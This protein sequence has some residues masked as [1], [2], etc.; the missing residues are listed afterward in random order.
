VSAGEAAG[1][2]PGTGRLTRKQQQ[3]HTRSC[4]LHSATRVLTRRGMHRA[5]ID[6]IAQDAGFT[7]GAFYANFKSKEELFLAMLDERFAARLAELDRV[8]DTDAS[9]EDQAQNAGMDFVR[10]I[11]GEQEWGR[12]FFEFAV[13]ASRDEEFRAEFTTRVRAL[14]HRIATR[15]EE[16]LEGLDWTPPI[17]TEE[18]ARLTFAMANGVA[19]ENL[20]DPGSV[21]P[22]LNGTMLT[23][24]FVGLRAASTPSP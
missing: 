21:S 18:A 19:L 4:L 8:M 13:H 6:E 15:L 2:A 12:L 20:I 1:D 3:A 16:R 5:S 23:A 14:R 9:V 7:K 17:S 24:F 22:E 11:Q 10:A